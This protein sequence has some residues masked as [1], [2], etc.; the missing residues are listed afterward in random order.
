MRSI[1]FECANRHEKSSSSTAP[2]TC[3]KIS[4]HRPPLRN[5]F[6][7]LSA[8]IPPHDLNQ[9]HANKE[10]WIERTERKK[11]IRHEQ[12]VSHSSHL[13]C[14]RNIEGAPPTR[15]SGRPSS[16]MQSSPPSKATQVGESPREYFHETK[17]EERENRSTPIDQ[18]INQSRS[19]FFSSSSFFPAAGAPPPG[20]G[21]STFSPSLGCSVKTTT[22]S[23]SSVERFLSTY[24][25]ECVLCVSKNGVMSLA[26][27][28]LARV[29]FR[30][31]RKELIEEENGVR[32]KETY[33][34]G[35]PSQKLI[36][37][38]VM[39]GMRP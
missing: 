20:V 5:E 18:S 26:C 16:R 7:S 2:V 9:S 23:G 15:P 39:P 3:R 33:R 12:F 14:L 25:S 31:G 11:L 6:L 10:T 1:A 38:I 4:V 24:L 27:L 17:R 37:G 28:V 36:M 32:K 22:N 35:W 29:G 21:T 34:S 8:S 30:G 19:S 13:S